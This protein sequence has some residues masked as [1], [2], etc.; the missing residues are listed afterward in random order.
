MQPKEKTDVINQ[1]TT[2][3]LIT[4][5]NPVRYDFQGWPEYQIRVIDLLKALNI[6]ID[7]IS[8]DILTKHIEV[9]EDDGMG[10]AGKTYKAVDC[11]VDNNKISIWI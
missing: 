3:S 9:C 10:Y 7:N 5:D 2:T 8:K 11:G 4:Q 6:P 1:E